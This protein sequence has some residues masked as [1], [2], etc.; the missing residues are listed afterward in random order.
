MKDLQYFWYI[1][2]NYF[3]FN[4]LIYYFLPNYMIDFYFGQNKQLM[5][6]HKKMFFLMLP[7]R[8]FNF[9]RYRKNA[10]RF[11][12]DSQDLEFLMRDGSHVNWPLSF[13]AYMQLILSVS[14]LDSLTNKVRS[15]LYGI[16]AI[17]IFNEN[18]LNT[19]IIAAYLN[20]TAL[21]ETQRVNTVF[22]DYLFFRK[23]A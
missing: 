21:Y 13:P 10:Y 20:T 5:I 14:T 1:I 4:L 17:W 16:D 23:Y 6:L 7:W 11:K 19:Y 8:T 12:L 22:I 2:L 18:Q 15:F 9:S 3:G